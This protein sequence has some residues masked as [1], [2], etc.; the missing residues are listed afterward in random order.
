MVALLTLRS[1]STFGNSST[2]IYKD[3]DEEKWPLFN[4]TNHDDF[5]LC[6]LRVTSALKSRE[7]QEVLDNEN[8]ELIKSEKV[9][10][11]IIMRLGDNPLR[12]IQD[13]LDAKS[14]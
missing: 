5:L 12:A 9:L 3:K 4:G 13:C 10:N 14:A 7:L 6:T 1:D 11:V 8:V 2:M